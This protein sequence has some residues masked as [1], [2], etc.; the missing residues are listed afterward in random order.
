VAFSQDGHAT[1]LAG[2]LDVVAEVEFGCAADDVCLAGH[3]A[4][5]TSEFFPNL[6]GDDAPCSDLRWLV[7][8]P[9]GVLARYGDGEPALA[10]A[11]DR[12]PGHSR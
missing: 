3:P 9:H 5:P 11:A 2:R 1:V 4:R 8:G 10:P 7:A 6:Q 12:C